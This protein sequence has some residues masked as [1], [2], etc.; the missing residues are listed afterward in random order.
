MTD[1]IDLQ[2]FI[3]G[4]V[5]EADELVAAASAC[6]REVEAGNTANQ[7]KPKAVRDLFRALHTIKGLAGMIG[8]EP[9]VEIAHALETLVKAA[10]RGGG[11][12]RAGAV[13]VSMQALR[14]IGERV[15]EV[16]E[17][18]PV[19]RVSATLLD[20]IAMT[21]IAS[22][23]PQAPPPIA[24]AWDER[25]APGERQHLFQALRAGAHAY[26]LV[27]RPSEAHSA[28]G[29]TIAT[30]RA[31]LAEHGD[32]VKVTPRALVAPE[33]GVVFDLLVLSDATRE[34]LADAAKMPVDEIVAIALPADAAP[35][36]EPVVAF[37]ADDD[38]GVVT[39]G[40]SIVRVE[41]AR[42]DDLQEQ[43]STLVVSRFRIAREIAR[44][45]EHGADVR[46]IREVAELQTRQLRDLRRAILR[47]RLIRVS[48][49]LEP[50]AL[51]VRS[52]SRPNLREV[53]LELDASDAEL[54]KAVADQLM[55]AIMHL[56]R[57]AVDHAI[58]PIEERVARGKPKFGTLRIRC[59]AVSGNL[60]ELEVSDD[61]RGIDR[62]VVGRRANRTIADDAELLDVLTTPGFSTRDVA[63]ETSGRGLGMDIVRKIAVDRLGGEL[64]VATAIGAGT[65]FRLR[66][67]VTIAIV[68]VFSFACGDQT[69]VV[70][71]SAVE[72]IFELDTSKQ[73]GPPTPG[74]RGLT[75]GLV[76]RGGH[77][78]PLI[79]LGAMLAIDDGSGVKKALV[80]RRNGEATA[81]AVDRMLGRQEVVVRPIDDVL[82]RMPGIA[83][84]T[85]LGDGR[86]TLVLDLGELGLV[87]RNRK[88][89]A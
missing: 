89:T 33:R 75:I 87:A 42:L 20:S 18:R 38:R 3:G 68:D 50:L 81:F 64:T 43:M 15:R 48:E 31:H 61:G 12:L 41:L 13:E 25:L 85:D 9:I 40:R 16:A 60:I 11:R 52:L 37:E 30:V 5:V 4:F 59:V 51:L 24:A 22:E 67:P 72:E 80:V 69:F 45:A 76:E 23:A 65:T 88:A 83:G 55:P 44:L 36:P 70:P 7:S 8:V 47:A 17:Q 14:A 6:L 84:A 21:D 26:S 78:L 54:D 71:V 53:R 19:T 56:V 2:D 74:A 1:Q 62:D 32:L 79:A 35:P 39:L 29:T 27:F 63:N 46:R 86:P 28:Q 82:V 66:V 58:E 49:I 34:V 10:D 57:N 77:A 73:I